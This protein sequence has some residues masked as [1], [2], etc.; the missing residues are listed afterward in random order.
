MCGLIGCFG[1][2]LH[3]GSRSDLFRARNSL[4]T[5]AAE[6]VRAD[7]IALSRRKQG[8]ESPRERQLVR[9]HFDFPLFLAVFP[10]PAE[11]VWANLF[12]LCASSL[13]TASSASPT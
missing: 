11:S 10:K 6:A 2:R 7:G 1:L 8:F 13:I 5:A 4:G 9:F 3:I 12:A